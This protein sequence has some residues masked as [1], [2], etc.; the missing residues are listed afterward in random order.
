MAAAPRTP[1]RSRLTGSAG[2]LCRHCVQK[3]CVDSLFGDPCHPLHVQLSPPALQGGELNAQQ[4]FYFSDPGTG[5]DSAI[6]TLLGLAAL[7]RFVQSPSS[8]P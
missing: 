8:S 1:A 4:S 6:K 2:P 7:D 3:L 5:T